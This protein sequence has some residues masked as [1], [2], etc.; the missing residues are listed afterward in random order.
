MDSAY[1]DEQYLAQPHEPSVPRTKSSRRED[2]SGMPG[3]YNPHQYY[4]AQ[5]D[6]DMDEIEKL[7][8]KLLNDCSRSE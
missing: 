4:D 1:A 3:P 2:D 8:A 6:V 7:K 5:E